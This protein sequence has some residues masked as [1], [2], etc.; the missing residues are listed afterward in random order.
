[1]GTGSG[2]EGEAN[3]A[4]MRVGPQIPKQ[5]SRGTMAHAASLALT[6]TNC[7][8]TSRWVHHMTKDLKKELMINTT[9]HILSMQL[10][11]RRLRERP[12]KWWPHRGQD[13]GCLRR[14]VPEQPRET[15]QRAWRRRPDRRQ[16]DAGPS[17]HTIFAARDLKCYSGAVL[18]SPGVLLAQDQTRV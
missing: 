5:A 10:K 9:S 15:G 1:M 17:V 14:S 18:F 7:S 11:L 3:V 13:H 16:R 6:A 12:P 4:T 2:D 8:F